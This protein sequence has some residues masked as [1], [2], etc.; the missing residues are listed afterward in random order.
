MEQG[1]PSD[2]KELG[3]DGAHEVRAPI[4]LCTSENIKTSVRCI[5]GALRWELRRSDKFFHVF[6]QTL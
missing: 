2:P 1:L 6:R 3:L 4:C 5:Q